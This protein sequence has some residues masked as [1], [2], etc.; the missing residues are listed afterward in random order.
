MLLP[1]PAIDVEHANL[2]WMN[3]ETTKK[4]TLSLNPKKFRVLFPHAE[5]L[6]FEKPGTGVDLTFIACFIQIPGAVRC[7]QPLANLFRWVN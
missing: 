1:H 7:S 6:P 2:K 5:P 4:L 3:E